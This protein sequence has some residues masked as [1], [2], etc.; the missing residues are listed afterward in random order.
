VSGLYADGV[1]EGLKAFREKYGISK[2]TRGVIAALNQAAQAPTVGTKKPC[3]T[4]V[5]IFLAY[6]NGRK[7]SGKLEVDDLS[8]FNQPVVIWF[9]L[10]CLGERTM[11]KRRGDSWYSEVPEETHFD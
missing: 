8:A 9:F 3:G 1:V 5:E 7:D 6:Y 11:Y 10:S 4:L 2:Y